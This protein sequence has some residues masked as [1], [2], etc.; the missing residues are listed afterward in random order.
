MKFVFT[1]YTIL[2]I[3]V[4]FAAFVLASSPA[5]ILHRNTFSPQ[6][7]PD[8]ARIQA[9]KPPTMFGEPPA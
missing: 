6:Y 8:R 1:F 4:G 9:K 5:A 2:H 3:P 7:S